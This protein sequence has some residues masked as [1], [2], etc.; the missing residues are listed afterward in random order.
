MRIC[1]DEWMVE[2]D[3]CYGLKGADI[4]SRPRAGAP[5]H[6]S[7]T[8]ATS[9]AP[10]MPALPC[11]G[12]AP[13]SGGPPPQPRL[14]SQPAPVVARS[15]YRMNSIVSAVIDLDNDGPRYIRRL[16]AAHARRLHGSAV[17]SP[18][19]MPAAANDLRE[20]ILRQRRPERTAF[21]PPKRETQATSDNP[22]MEEWPRP[23]PL[24]TVAL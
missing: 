18:D 7:A 5:T 19:R 8:S 9:P 6:S 21:S 15:E 16:Q 17:P 4:L 2:L 3:R 12:D 13:S 24:A 20:T 10:W 11:A 1:A 23:G 14:S 22:L